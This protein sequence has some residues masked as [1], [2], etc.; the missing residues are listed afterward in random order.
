MEDGICYL[1]RRLHL[2]LC[3]EL[4]FRAVRPE[5]VDVCESVDL[6]CGH[7]G[8]ADVGRDAATQLAVSALAFIVTNANCREPPVESVDLTGAAGEGFIQRYEYSNRSALRMVAPSAAALDMRFAA[9][10]EIGLICQL[11]II[12]GLDPSRRCFLGRQSEIAV[13]RHP[14]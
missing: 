6:E 14:R 1:D 4:S 3:R 12:F 10:C 9:S 8:G 7:C 11:E 2:G 13:D 5:L